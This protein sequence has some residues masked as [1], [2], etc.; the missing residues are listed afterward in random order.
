M[1]HFVGNDNRNF[2]NGTSEGDLMEGFGGDDFLNGAGGNDDVRGGDGD[3][4]LLGGNDN[5]HLDGGEGKDRLDGGFGI[6]TLLGGAGDDI[7]T[8]VSN[9]PGE[10]VDGGSGIDML[11]FFAQFSATAVSFSVANAST[12]QTV[13]GSTIVNVEQI[14]FTGS[15]NFDDTITGGDFNDRIMGMGGSDTLDGGGGNDTLDGYFG[16]DTVHGGSGDDVITFRGTEALI[17]G[18]SGIDFLKMTYGE[19]AVID[20]SDPSDKQLGQ[21]TVRNVEQVDYEGG[22][23]ANHITGGAYA[24]NL[25][26]NSGDDVL[27]GGGGNDSLSGGEGLDSLKGGAGDDLLQN[28]EIFNALGYSLLDGGEGTDTLELWVRYYSGAITIDLA[29][30]GGAVRNIER[31][32]FNGGSGGNDVRALAGAD[33]LRGGADA[34]HFE[35]GG[36]DDYIEGFEGNDVLHG[37]SGNDYLAGGFGFDTIH[38]GDDNDELRAG[39]DGSRMDGGSGNDL[40]RGYVGADVLIGGLGDDQIEGSDG[41]D[42]AEFDYAPPAGSSLR[43]AAVQ[44]GD[45]RD[46][47]VEQL[48]SADGLATV[49]FE[50]RFGSNA[51]TVTGRGPAAGYG[52]D[53]LTDVETLRFALPEYDYSGN[54]TLT[55][56][57]GA[58]LLDGRAGNDRIHGNGGNDDLRGGTGDD[59]IHV[60]GAGLVTADGGSGFDQLE[61]QWSDSAAAVTMSYP[62]SDPSG[63]LTGTI[64]DGAGRRVDYSGI[65]AVFVATGS[66]ND[67]IY[68]GRSAGS[69][70]LGGATTAFTARPASNGSTAAK[71]WTGSGRRWAWRL[72]RSSGTSRPTAI[73][74]PWAATPTSKT[75]SAG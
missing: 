6:D 2:F 49:V 72:A 12:P 51:I 73:R 45:A 9:G 35:G 10:Y 43:I 15:D 52:T 22:Y 37:G 67:L 16:A 50:V 27:D 71:A 3:D 5:D 39:P 75:C 24:D 66:G 59:W 60:L 63:G 31:I 46:Y 65:E 36:G 4:Q 57:S 44:G 17:D 29:D 7:L 38:G 41:A 69:A 14:D 20:F 21:V 48:N 23:G 64:G 40:L 18:G 33:T 8:G 42:V 74:A 47:N 62:G 70:S 28:Y 61:I 55:G 13:A 32:M 30:P 11:T 34:D 1:A 54:D 19:Y 68:S 25:R 53:I 58:N 56:D 26:G